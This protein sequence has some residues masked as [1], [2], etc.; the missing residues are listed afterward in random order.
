MAAFDGRTLGKLSGAQIMR[1]F[2]FQ[3]PGKGKGTQ[4]Q[5]I[6]STIVSFNVLYFD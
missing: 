6:E 3:S 4:G 2:N 1:S 5:V